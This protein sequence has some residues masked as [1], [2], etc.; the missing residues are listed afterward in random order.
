MKLQDDNTNAKLFKFN[1]IT[2][3]AT[4]GL[5]CI[6]GMAYGRN[7]GTYDYFGEARITQILKF[8]F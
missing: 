6:C 3:H 7:R 4:I 2:N 5:T 1:L 8:N